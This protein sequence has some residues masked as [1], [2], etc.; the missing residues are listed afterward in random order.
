MPVA[1]IKVSYQNGIAKFSSR[2]DAIDFARAQSRRGF[3]EVHAPDGI[4]GQFQDGRATPE[5]EHLDQDL[6]APS[7]PTTY[8]SI[9]AEVQQRFAA[10]VEDLPASARTEQGIRELLDGVIA[11]VMPIQ[12]D[13][14]CEALISDLS[15]GFPEDKSIMETDEIFEAIRGSIRESLLNDMDSTVEEAIEAGQDADTDA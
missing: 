12:N 1:R 2:Q 8:A 6:R 14:V 15:L 10:S 3:T 9:L 4:I 13:A 7:E 11:S 5:F